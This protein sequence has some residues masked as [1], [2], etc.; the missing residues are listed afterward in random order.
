MVYDFATGWCSQCSTTDSVDRCLY[1]YFGQ[2]VMYSARAARR[3]R[4][5]ALLTCS[6]Q[7]LSPQVYIAL[8][9]QALGTQRHP[10]NR[11]ASS[12]LSDRRIFNNGLT[13][14]P[15]HPRDGRVGGGQ[16][17]PEL[18]VRDRLGRIA[19]KASSRQ[20]KPAF[21]PVCGVTRD[22]MSADNCSLFDTG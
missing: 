19:V 15:R 13:R 1:H 18:Q 14:A 22:A 8:P 20:Q 10:L 11:T 5:H 21:D 12:R 16:W 2:L 6:M 3:K 7:N 17:L 4:R 9:P